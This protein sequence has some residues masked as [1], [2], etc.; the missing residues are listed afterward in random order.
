[1]YFYC[2]APIVCLC[3]LIAC[4]CIFIVPAGTLRLPWLRFFRA[5]SSVVRQMPGK[6]H[7]DGARPA[8]LLNLC[9]AVC[10]V[11]FVLF[12]VLFVCKCVLYYSHRVATQL[13]LTNISYHIPYIICGP[14]SSVGIAISYGLNG[15]GIETRWERDFPH[16]SK[17]SLGPTQP[18]VQWIPGHSRG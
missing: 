8:L 17:P 7:K 1:M 5:F 16:L 4:L 6:A 13:Q 18:P 14:G 15:P 2:Y 11:C 10:I 12:C 3:I 9:V